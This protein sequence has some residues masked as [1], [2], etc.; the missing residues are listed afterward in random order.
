MKINQLTEQIIGAA[1]TVHRRLGPGLLESAYESCLA[2]ELEKLGLYIERQKPV[3]LI[4]DAVKLEC[5][6]RADLVVANLVV[7]ELKC[8]EQ[9]HPVDEAQLLSHLRL[10]GFPVGLLINFQVTVLKD[11]IRRIVNNYREDSFAA[12]ATKDMTQSSQR[13]AED[14]E[15]SPRSQ[16]FSVTSA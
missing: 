1:I 9:I 16:R 8:K 15:I 4:Y 14:A 11:G 12:F 13:A 6:F 2:H 10:L 3:P 5:G 7:V